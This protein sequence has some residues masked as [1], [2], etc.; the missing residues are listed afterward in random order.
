MATN[1]PYACVTDEY[2]RNVP[3]WAGV[4]RDEFGN[5][6][7]Q[8]R[9]S[10]T[11]IEGL[12]AVLGSCLSP[13]LLQD[14]KH[15][16]T[17]T[18][19]RI[20]L[21]PYL[22]A[23]I[24][25]SN[26]ID[27]PI[28]RQFLPF[29]S[30]FLDNHPFA[31]D[32]SLNEDGD[33]VAPFLV[34]RYPDRALFLPLTVCPVYCAFCTRSRLV[35]GSTAVKAKETYGASPEAWEDTFAY[36]RA[37]PE[38]ED[39][40]ISGGDAAM[41]R[42]DAIESIGR[43]LVEMPHVRRLRYATRGLAAIPMKITS[44]DAWVG[45]LA[46]VSD[47][48]RRAMKEVCVH[49]HVN[50]GTEITEWTVAASQR[51]IDLGIR[52]RNQSV[53]LRGVNDSLDVMHQLIKRLS[54][55]QF[56][57]YLVYLH[58][59]VPGC[60]HLRTRL[61]DALRMSKALLGTTAGFNVPRFVCDAPGGGGKREIFSHECYDPELGVSAWSAPGVK[62]GHLFFYFDPVD[63]LPESGRRIWREPRERDKR[64]AAFKA[65]AR[66]CQNGDGPVA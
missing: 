27:D 60:E 63:L 48:G 42:P 38:I 23:L 3:G 15:G 6:R 41:L 1:V 29:G 13:G 22:A 9:H 61:S 40:V 59:M 45:A 20:R 58:D 66:S 32:D 17:R 46:R 19:M 21:T 2:W 51:L 54:Y 31:A 39:V 56:Q 37:H 30:R 7:W 47:A 55:V 34:H 33:R 25:W 10:I 28:G 49:T 43:T 26:P 4:S 18:P 35:G 50:V 12:A 36:L 53:L 5:H 24:D 64:V 8:D 52:V 14:L 65:L 16:L 62:P 11:S 44:D 57:P